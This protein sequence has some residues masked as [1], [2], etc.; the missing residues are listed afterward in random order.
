M[1]K[2]SGNIKTA[3]LLLTGALCICL[4]FAWWNG[5]SPSR[6]EREGRKETA[7]VIRAETEVLAPNI[8]LAD[9]DGKRLKLRELY[10]EKPVCLYFWHP[11]NENTAIGLGLLQELQEKE[12]N[13]IY[14]CAVTL[15]GRREEAYAYIE[16]KGYTFLSYTT[17]VRTLREYAIKA[18]PVWICIDKGGKIKDKSEDMTIK[19]LLYILSG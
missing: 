16:K 17:D 9:A 15:D 18:P 11:W 8:I 3:V 2:R 10:N 12:G 19:K 5:K 14:V 4:L 7:P 13:R 1:M 6:L